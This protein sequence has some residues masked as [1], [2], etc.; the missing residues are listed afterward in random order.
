MSNAKGLYC[1]QLTQLPSVAMI[2]TM[3]I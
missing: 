2:P 3:A 1:N